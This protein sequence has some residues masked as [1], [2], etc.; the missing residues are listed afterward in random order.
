MLFDAYMRR[1]ALHNK[2]GLGP[3]RE[4]NRNVV[5]RMGAATNRKVEE[6]HN[7]QRNQPLWGDCVDV[8]PPLEIMVLVCKMSCWV[9]KVLVLR[10]SR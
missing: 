9:G 6:E 1:N 4:V 2:A 10:I 3:N 5:R 7:K 8:S